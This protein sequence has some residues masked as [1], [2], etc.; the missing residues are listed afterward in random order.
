LTAAIAR[1]QGRRTNRNQ[2]T[3]RPRQVASMLA[4]ADRLSKFDENDPA[5]NVIQ[6]F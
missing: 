6:Q 1:P 5:L 3:T 4:T 2:W